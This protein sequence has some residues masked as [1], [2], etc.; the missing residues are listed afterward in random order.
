MIDYP[1]TL[2]FALPGAIVIK[3]ARHKQKV[4]AM[5]GDGGFLMN[6]QEPETPSRLR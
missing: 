5:C 3:L 1:C 4:I 6:V 2:R